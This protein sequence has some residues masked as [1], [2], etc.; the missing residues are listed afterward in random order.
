MIITCG[1]KK[2]EYCEC[3]MKVIDSCD[4]CNQAVEVYTDKDKIRLIYEAVSSANREKSA[5]EVNIMRAILGHCSALNND[6]DDLFYRGYTVWLVIHKKY[7]YLRHRDI[8]RAYEDMRLI[9]MKIPKRMHREVRRIRQ[10]CNK[11]KQY[12]YK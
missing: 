3:Y 2:N 9:G 11:H 5:H 10:N 7:R 12:L 8:L 6:A 1:Y 4:N